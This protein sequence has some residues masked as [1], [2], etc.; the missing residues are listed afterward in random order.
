MDQS[1]TI[2]KNQKYQNSDLDVPRER[3]PVPDDLEYSPTTVVLAHVLMSELSAIGSAARM[4]EERWEELSPRNRDQLLD[5]ITDTVRAGLDRL[6]VMVCA[7]TT[8]WD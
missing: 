5:M 3:L 7:A 1:V 4:L 8:C 6:H 2:A